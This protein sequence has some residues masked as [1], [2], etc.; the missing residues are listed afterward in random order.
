[1]DID[2]VPARDCASTMLVMS[3]MSPLYVGAGR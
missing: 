2:V 3:E 1:M